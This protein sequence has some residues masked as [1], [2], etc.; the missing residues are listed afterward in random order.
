MYTY[1]SFAIDGTF[2]LL[3]PVFYSLLLFLIILFAIIMLSKAKGKFINGFSVCIVSV[4]C[5][6]IASQM[7]FYDAIIVDELNLAGDEIA[8]YSF[9]AILALGLLNPLLYYRKQKK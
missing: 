1:D 4:I 8:T 6:L 5:I 7:L 2:T 3:R 9:I